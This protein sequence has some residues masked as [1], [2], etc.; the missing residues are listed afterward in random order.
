MQL[1]NDSLYR[2]IE[3]EFISRATAFEVSGSVEEL[4]MMLKGIDV[5][6]AAI[7]S[8]WEYTTSR[9]AFSCFPQFELGAWIRGSAVP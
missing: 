9:A 3:D 7:R 8:S 5:K 1:F 6:S 2:F 4:K